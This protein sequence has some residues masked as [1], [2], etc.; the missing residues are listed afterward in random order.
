M[1]GTTR[2]GYMDRLIQKRGRRRRTRAQ[3]VDLLAASFEV[4]EDGC[5]LWTRPLTNEGYARL[6]WKHQDGPNVPGG[7]RVVLAAIGQ[8][9]P[10]GMV[11]D[12]AC[13][14][15][16]CIN[17]DHLDVVV[18][19]ENVMRSPIAIGALNA[20]KTHCAQGHHYSADNTYVWR[21]TKRSTT[22]RICKT[23][24]RAHARRRY[25]AKKE[26]AA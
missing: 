24:Q 12:H 13:R 16:A 22:V 20:A 8:P 3:I 1:A 4:S 17:P 18:Q 7:H 26:T 11:V 25:L 6:N 5:W 9:V 23:C 2:R 19:R 15:R 14:N 10:M 21:S